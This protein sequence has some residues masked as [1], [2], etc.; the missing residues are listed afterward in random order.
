[1]QEGSAGDG[2]A[3]SVWVGLAS[4]DEMTNM[5]IVTMTH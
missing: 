5:T 4:V 1:M 2:R 3:L